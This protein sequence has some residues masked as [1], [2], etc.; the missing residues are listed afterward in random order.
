MSWAPGAWA[1]GSWAGTAWADAGSLVPVPDVVGQ[2]KAAGIATLTGDGFTVA[3]RE[4]YSSTVAA[5]LII[6]QA[7]VGGS[8]AFAG[9][10]VTITVSLGERGGGGIKKRPQRRYYVEIDGQQFTVDGPNEALQLLQ[11]AKELAEAAAE[12]SAKAVERKTTGQPKPIKLQAPKVVASP[13]LKI[14]LAP[15]RQEL[16]QI[17]DAAAVNAELRLLLKRAEEEDEEETLLLL[18]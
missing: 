1:T 2:T 9:S 5:G 6:S 11:R 18:V 14:D 16:R 3:Q 15:I 13:E 8:E 17:Y 4:E 12:E 10:T 7:P